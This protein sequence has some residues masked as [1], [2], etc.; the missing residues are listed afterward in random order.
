MIDQRPKSAFRFGAFELD[1]NA[2]ELREDG[3]PLQLGRKPLVALGLLLERHGET[4]TREQL[5]DRL[6]GETF[7]EFEDNLNH[8]VRRLRE[9]L[10]DSAEDPRFIGT[11]PGVGYRFVAS[12][13][14]LPA[15]ASPA[16]WKGLLPRKEVGIAAVALAIIA[17]VLLPGRLKDEA[18]EQATLE[19]APLTTYPG[20]E[21]FP[22]LS[23]DGS[24]VAFSWNGPAQ[25]NHDIHIQG[26]TGGKPL[27]LTTD[28]RPDTSPAYSPDGERIAF[29]RILD[30]AETQVIVIPTLGGRERVLGEIVSQRSVG[31][32]QP[33]FSWTPDSK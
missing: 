10:H 31:V 32:P 6:W 8:V 15:P 20:S 24:H 29:A 12:V 13:E 11:V 26:V 5:R 1:L 16:T 18:E 25:S 14:S 28:P 22:S 19:A 33:Y 3:A 27:R 17:V 30:D 2:F 4:V 21:G 9:A 23:P 7:V